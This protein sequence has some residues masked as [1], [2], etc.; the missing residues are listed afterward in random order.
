MPLVTGFPLLAALGAGAEARSLG[1]AG[2]A[3][4]SWARLRPRRLELVARDPGLRRDGLGLALAGLRPRA[5]ARPSPS[6]SAGARRPLVVARLIGAR[7]ARVMTASSAVTAIRPRW[8]WWQGLGTSVTRSRASSGS[9]CRWSSTARS[10]PRCRSLVVLLASGLLVA[11]GA[12]AARGRSLPLVGWVPALAGAFWLRA[13]P[14]RTTCATSTASTRRSSPSRAPASRRSGVGGARGDRAGLALVLPWACGDRLLAGPGASL[15][16]PTGCG[17]CPRSTTPIAASRP[18]PQRLR[19]PAVRGP[20]HA[21][22][23]GAVIASQAWN[24]RIPGD[25]LRF[26]DEVD[27]DPAPG[28]GPVGAALARDAA[29][30]GVPRAAAGD[31]RLV[32]GEQAG[33]LPVFRG[34][35]PPYDEARPVPRDAI[36]SRRSAARR[37]GPRPSTVIR[38]HDWRPPRAWHVAAASSFG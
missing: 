23:G 7:G 16:T 35:R 27:L 10:A 3:S 20:H 9:R 29:G 25:P 13:A 12:A 11:L 4:S 38:R 37:S 33:G 17:R 32:R 24:E 30:R 18:A 19:E 1:L 22:D 14:G 21:R 5:G 2:A 15:P 28:L 6:R 36:R 8:L 26:R 31:G 34:F